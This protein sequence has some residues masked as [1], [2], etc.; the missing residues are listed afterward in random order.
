M[1]LVY[2]VPNTDRTMHHS[3]GGGGG[4]SVLCAFNLFQKNKS[5]GTAFGKPSLGIRRLPSAFFSFIEDKAVSQHPSTS[6][7][8]NKDN[9]IYSY[10]FL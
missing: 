7:L 5:N 9:F 3:W 4:G 6:I 2:P 8:A 1:A 10:I